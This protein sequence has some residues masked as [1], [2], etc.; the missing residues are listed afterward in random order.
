M[1]ELADDDEIIVAEEQTGGREDSRI[2]DLEQRDACDAKV[3]A[4]VHAKARPSSVC[5]GACKPA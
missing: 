2:T 4:K 5:D 1:H 3:H